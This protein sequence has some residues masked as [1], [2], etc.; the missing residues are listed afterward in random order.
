MQEA[1][2]STEREGDIETEK[3]RQTETETG[4]GWTF[5]TSKD[6]PSGIL[7]PERTYLLIL[8]RQV[9][10]LCLPFLLKSPHST[11]LSYGLVAVS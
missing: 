1:D 5:E 6:A 10:H 11:Y 3:D 8:P 7:P 2:R 4:P 9:H